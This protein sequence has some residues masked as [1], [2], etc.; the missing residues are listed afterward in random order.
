M[1]ADYAL[2]DDEL[3]A[4]CTVRRGGASGPGGQH[5]N[6]NAT[7]I[8]ITHTASG[9]VSQ[10]HVYRDGRRNQQEALRRLRLRLALLERGG[11]QRAWLADFQGSGGRLKVS[12]NNPR[13]HL[14]IA[15]LFDA[16]AEADFELRTAA[17][18]LGTSSSQLIKCL[19]IDKEVW[20]R[21]RPSAANVASRPSVIPS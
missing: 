4:R 12:A 19:A 3:L 15:C 11:A 14:V 7:G 2:P 1:P 9:A 10:H 16:L 5:A 13:F 18:S 20:T 17:E 21:Y 6:R 8:T